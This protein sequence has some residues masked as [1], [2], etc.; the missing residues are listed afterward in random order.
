MRLTTDQ[1]SHLDTSII[2]TDVREEGGELASPATKIETDP[3]SQLFS[4]INAQ[5]YP[6]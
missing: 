2:L 1:Y 5:R 6:K 4:S 3:V